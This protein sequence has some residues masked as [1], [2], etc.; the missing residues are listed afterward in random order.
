M[1]KLTIILYILGAIYILNLVS[2]DDFGSIIMDIVL[3]ALCFY[4]GHR[5][6]KKNANSSV[7]V[8]KANTHNSS[9]NTIH[10][11]SAHSASAGSI[12]TKV[13]GVT[14][15]ND[16]GTDRQKLLQSVSPGDTL[17]LKPYTYNGAPAIMVVHALGCIGNLKATL[18]AD[19][20]K[21]QHNPHTAKVLDITG[22]TNGKSYGCNIE[23]TE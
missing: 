19:L 6:S 3:A 18:A 5:F 10:N 15:K 9:T 14:F 11:T 8:S 16:D 7:P 2:C 17:E 23:I 20:C 1:K 13:V 22:G 21:E 12:R 4:F